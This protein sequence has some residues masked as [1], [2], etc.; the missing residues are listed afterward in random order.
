MKG[1]RSKT[2]NGI[3][4]LNSLL[5]RIKNVGTFSLLAEIKKGAV[6]SL[7]NSVLL[8]VSP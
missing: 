2:G 6:N 1:L 4:K 7:E 8:K 5:R 3:G